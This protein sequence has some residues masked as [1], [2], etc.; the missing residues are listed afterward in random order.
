[1]SLKV[2]FIKS[3]K[4]RCSNQSKVME[5]LFFMYPNLN[6]M[7][8][9]WRYSSKCKLFCFELISDLFFKVARHVSQR[10]S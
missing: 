6:E 9:L 7:I 4:Y 3:K 2:F 1:M 5:M 10:E 8:H